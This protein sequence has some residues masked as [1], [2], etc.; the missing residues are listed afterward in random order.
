MDSF[1]PPDHG[2]SNFTSG[3]LFPNGSSGV[4]AVVNIAIYSFL[5]T[6]L[7]EIAAGESE[8]PEKSVP[9]AVKTVFWRI[10]LFYVLSIFILAAIQVTK[11]E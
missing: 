9:K 3:G 11:N 4:I 10:A 8:N 6:E 2:I 5:G 7:I 1:C